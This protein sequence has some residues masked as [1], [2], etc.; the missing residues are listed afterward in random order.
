MNRPA[1]SAARQKAL[2]LAI[3][4]SLAVLFLLN[5]FYIAAGIV[6]SPVWLGVV[7]CNI[8]ITFFIV[9]FCRKR[10]VIALFRRPIRL[11]GFLPGFMLLFG[12]CSIALVTRLFFQDIT[13]RFFSAW[14]Y[15]ALLSL[16]LVPVI[17]EVMF[18]FFLTRFIGHFSSS[19]MASY[20]SVIVFAAAHGLPVYEWSDIALVS[21]PLGP[22]LMG[23]ICEWLFYRYKNLVYPI[24]F[25]ACANSTVFVFSLIDKRWLEWLK[26]FY[27]S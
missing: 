16:T 1:G 14:S 12:S 4:I 10:L 6:I 17:E 22:L 20:L 27:L 24:F 18:R 23:G 21:V 11:T 3:G 15:A 7:S 5:V 19:I 25:H 13:P 2:F 9:Y 8:L 26:L